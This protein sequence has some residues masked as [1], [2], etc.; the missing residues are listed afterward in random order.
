[1]TIVVTAKVTDGIVLAADSAAS[2]FLPTAGGVIAKI[3]N[4]ANKIFNLRKVWSIGAM[5]YGAG[6]IGASSV[7]TLSKDLR[8]KFCDPHNQDYYLNENTY[9]I[10]E[11]AIK[12]RKF[13]FEEI[14]LPAFSPPPGDFFM[15]YRICG[16][17]ANAAMSEV[18]EFNILGANCGAPYR[19]QAPDEF[20]LRWAGENEAL[21]RLHYGAT[22]NI[23]T[24]L[25]NKGYV[26]QADVEAAFSDYI[27]H[28]G[29]SLIVP[30]MPI[31]DAIDVARFAVETAAKYAKFGLRHETIGGPIDVAAIT[32]HEGFKWVMRKHYYTAGASGRLDSLIWPYG[33]KVAREA[34]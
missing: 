31:Q 7:E 11:V 9:T 23:K 34:V 26:Q 14:Y 16:Y 24:W 4:H 3:Y 28:F 22:V 29:A 10:E 15:G 1:M 5:V 13:L 21:D 19:I 6:G 17:S 8:K 12:A 30:A 32:K 27:N 2:F 25:V 18:W 20:G 33:V